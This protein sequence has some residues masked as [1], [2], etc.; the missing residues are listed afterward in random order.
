MG[1]LSKQCDPTYSAW[2]HS[3]ATPHRPQGHSKPLPSLSFL[4]PQHS[5]INT[6]PTGQL[7]T[8]L[9]ISVPEVQPLQNP[10]WQSHPPSWKNQPLMLLSCHHL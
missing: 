4:R 5:A 7:V 1:D 9:L 8:L 2:K 10:P 3:E 6:Y